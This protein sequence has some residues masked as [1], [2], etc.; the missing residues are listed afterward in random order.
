MEM[1]TMYLKDHKGPHAVTQC[2]QAPRTINFAILVSSISSPH[3]FGYFKPN[4][5]HISPVKYFRVCVRD[6]FFFKVLAKYVV[7]LI[8]IY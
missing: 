2:Q 4:P 7:K 3:T 5:R 1:V 8:V 6:S